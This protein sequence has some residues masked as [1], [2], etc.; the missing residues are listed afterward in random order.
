MVDRPA[1]RMGDAAGEGPRDGQD[2]D[3]A[4]HDEIRS[5][6]LKLL[7]NREHSRLELARK[8]C[9]RGYPPEAVQAVV[10]ALVANELLSEER[11]VEAY[12]AER[13]G[14]GFGPLRI[15]AELRDKGVADALIQPHLA[16]DDQRLLDY[17]ARADR[18]RFG[19]AA[20]ADRQEQVRRARFLEYRGFPSALIARLMSSRPASTRDATDAPHIEC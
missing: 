1:E 7:S 3:R 13:L 4:L 19:D 18:K 12:V 9:Q 2:L 11:L 16:L 15:R 20:A 10:E 8:L 14:K 6:A 17:A 5:R